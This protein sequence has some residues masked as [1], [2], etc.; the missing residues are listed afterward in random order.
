M[1]R[2]VKSYF[3]EEQFILLA[4]A[5]ACTQA[6]IL[7]TLTVIMLLTFHYFYL[8][9]YW[10]CT[11]SEVQQAPE[12]HQTQ[13]NKHL[14]QHSRVADRIWWIW[15]SHFVYWYRQILWWQKTVFIFS[16]QYD[17]QYRF[18]KVIH[19]TSICAHLMVNEQLKTSLFLLTSS[20]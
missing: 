19:T 2:W 12:V 13:T 5:T 20:D 11:S 4:D 9:F 16:F 3:T 14:L 8:I 7:A 15:L 17:P 18:P 10:E 1:K 6:Q